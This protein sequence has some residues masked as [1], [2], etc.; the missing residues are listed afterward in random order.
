MFS[1]ITAVA[2]PFVW[3]G[4]VLG[5]SF[6]EAPLKFRAPGITLPLGLG[7]GRLV[8]SVLNKLELVLALGLSA[9][10][11][12]GAIRGVPNYVLAAIVFILAAQTV[13]LLPTLGAR[14]DA[15][16]SGAE[17]PFSKLH[18]V[19]IVLESIKLIL[20]LTLGILT[21]KYYLNSANK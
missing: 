20:L 13:W 12:V 1:R 21:A 11:F 3:F 2:V 19:Y 9:V 17:A 10:T 7:I 15:V 16:I 4:L 6:I 8:F 18:I 14:T 5:L